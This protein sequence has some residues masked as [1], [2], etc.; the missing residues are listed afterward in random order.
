MQPDSEIVRAVL[1]GS[2]GAYAELVRRHEKAARAVAL[3]ILKDWHAAEDVVQD[4]FIRA[5]ERLGSLRN[6]TAFGSWLM[7]IARRRALDVV[8]GTPNADMLDPQ[9][10]SPAPS[11]ERKARLEETSELLLDA[12]M[13]LPEQERNVILLRHFSGC[14]VRTIA[15]DTGRS[16]GTV[17]K[18]ISR[19]HARLREMLQEHRP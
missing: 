5:Y 18:Q 11:P 7:Q 13:K 9:A 12:V 8:R 2:Q 15:Q 4:A 19:A 17:T 16:V 10:A 6:G 14:A 1:D 3:Q